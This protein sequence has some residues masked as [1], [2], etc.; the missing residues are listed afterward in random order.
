MSGHLAAGIFVALFVWNP[1]EFCRIDENY[2]IRK[3]SAG[4]SKEQRKLAD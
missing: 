1:K 2:T 4:V 3:V